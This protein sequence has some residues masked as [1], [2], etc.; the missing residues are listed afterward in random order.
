VTQRS[1]EEAHDYRYFPEPDLP[2]LFVDRAWLARLREQ[3]P[4]LPDARRAR[5]MESLGL[6]AYDADAL[7][8]DQWAAHLF[9]E[10]VA[11]GADAKKAA[12]WV[13]NDVARLRG[14]TEP[15]LSGTQLA[16]VIRLVEDGAIG[17]SAAR[18]LLPSVAESG[19]SA[20]ALVDELGLAQ[21]SDSAELEH[22]VRQIL[23]ANPA[24]VADYHGGKL[25][26]I[27]FLK[28]QV[29]KA[30]RGTSN[31]GVVEDLLK[32]LLSA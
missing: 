2:P 24:A 4:E 15:A 23:E 3:L 14:E 9:E 28:G 26:A 32:R 20:R 30:T 11:A 6:G 25:T 13:Q 7:S 31:Q 29:M 17:I 5:Y 8:T 16:E 21:V 12:N 19:K 1:K 22:T 27:N 10:T 18:Q